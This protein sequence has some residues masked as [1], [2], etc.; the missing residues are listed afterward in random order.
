MRS[1]Y[2]HFETPQFRI[3]SDSQI[4]E[5][6]YATLQILERTGVTVECE[7]AIDLLGEAGADVSNPKRV[8]IPANIVEQAIRTA[9][10]SFTLYTRD[11]EPAIALN[12]M[13]ESHFGAISDYDEYLDPY[14]RKRRP[15]YV[16]D[17]ADMAKVFDA[18]PNIEWMYT[19][20][21]F[22]TLPGG[23]AEK[24]AV[25]QTLFNS[26]KPIFVKNFIYIHV[27][28]CQFDIYL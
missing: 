8:K 12:G 24:V 6:H 17:I 19:V 23:L 9:P 11:G 26:S 21:A 22:P 15:C 5:L 4:E 25:L 7:E 3:L 28:A 13:K 2:I 16:E 20:G 27:S 10:K 1:N 18:L 14:T